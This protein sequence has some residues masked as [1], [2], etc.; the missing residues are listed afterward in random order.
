LK[1]VPEQARIVPFLNK[2]DLVFSDQAI[3][4]TVKEIMRRA[5]GRMGQV[6]VGSVTRG[7]FAVYR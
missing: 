5:G 1:H 7:L 2:Q 3:E 4:E 6:V